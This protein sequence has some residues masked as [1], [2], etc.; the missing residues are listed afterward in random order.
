MHIQETHR[1]IIN[2]WPSAAALARDLALPPQIVQKW[3]NRGSIPAVHWQDV[4][5]AGKTRHIRLTAD[6][7]LKASK[8]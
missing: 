8:W 5:F 2:L 1:D 3:R 6:R 4:I 7:L